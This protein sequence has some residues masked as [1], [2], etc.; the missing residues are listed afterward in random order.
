MD[1]I[2]ATIPDTKYMIVVL[3]EPSF[4]STVEPNIYS[5]NILPKR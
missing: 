1:M 5:A 4:L 2:P 3:R